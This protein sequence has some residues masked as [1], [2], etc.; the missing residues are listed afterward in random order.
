MCDVCTCWQVRGGAGKLLGGKRTESQ[1]AAG[2]GGYLSDGH[3]SSR[4]SDNESASVCSEMVGRA[5]NTVRLSACQSSLCL[6]SR[7]FAFAT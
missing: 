5:V 3:V 2:G 4:S 1:S 6:F 7:Q